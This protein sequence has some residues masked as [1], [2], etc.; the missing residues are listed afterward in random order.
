MISM[1]FLSTLLAL[2]VQVEVINGTRP[3]KPIPDGYVR[4]HVLSPHGNLMYT[5]SARTHQGK[6]TFQV[7]K[8]HL[9]GV[10][11]FTYA[12]QTFYS[13]QVALE[14]NPTLEIQVYEPS[15]DPGPL[16]YGRFHM[17]L[18]PLGKDTLY[19]NEI[20]TIRYDS[21][22]MYAGDA[23]ALVMPLEPGAGVGFQPLLPA[24]EDLWLVVNDTVYFTGR[25][26]P[27][28]QTVAFALHLPFKGSKTLVQ[29]LP[30]TLE[31]VDVFVSPL[32]E[33]THSNLQSQGQQALG[34]S[35]FNHY[36]GQNLDRVEITV[37]MAGA[38]AAGGP[39]WIL[40]LGGLIVLVLLILVILR[41]RRS[42]EEQP[43]A[44]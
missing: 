28:S 24:Q 41:A 15:D 12:G 14:G 5:D 35:V 17:V 36:T 13:E 23:P 20:Q 37:A 25:V 31:Q 11:S 43:P 7:E 32:L 1:V 8:E 33:V 19:V 30:D 27:G 16:S 38:A 10:A 42:G 18:I 9:F 40:I 34:G 4:L 22:Y 6:A 26:P 44:E 2:T 3:G 39:P 21:D 29:V